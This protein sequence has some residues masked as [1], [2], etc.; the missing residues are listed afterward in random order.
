MADSQL[1]GKLELEL[2]RA[3]VPGLG[4]EG[5]DHKTERE[6]GRKEERKGIWNGEVEGEWR[7]LAV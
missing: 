2:G 4:V 3:S 7:W 1:P 5:R 6:R